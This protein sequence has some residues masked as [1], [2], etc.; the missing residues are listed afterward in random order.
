MQSIGFSGSV[1]DTGLQN[2]TAMKSAGLHEIF[3][4]K[5][6]CKPEADFRQIILQCTCGSWA[7]V[8]VP[9]TNRP[10]NHHLLFD[11]HRTLDK[12]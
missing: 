8:C 2:F 6:S 12:Y 11:L 1:L 4:I 10:I 3:G 5:N 9:K 7:Q